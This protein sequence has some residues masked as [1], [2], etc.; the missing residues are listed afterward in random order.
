MI[1]NEYKLL[2]LKLGYELFYSDTDSLMI[3]GQLPE[4]YISST[5]LGKMKLEHQFKE[6]FFVMPK[7]YYLDYGDSQVY[8]CKGF[9]GDLTRADFEG[10]YNGE[11][12]DLKV[13][14]WSKD[15]VEGKVFIKSD[16]PYKLKVFDSL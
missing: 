8:K 4:E 10:L 5:V 12:L 2:A 11:T 13:T 7:V 3:S 15:R 14:K 9:P 1:I 6:A 16:L